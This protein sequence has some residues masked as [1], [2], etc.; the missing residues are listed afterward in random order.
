MAMGIW[1]PGGGGADL[2]VVTA[3]A[4]DVLAGKVIV[5]RMGNRSPE[6]WHY[7]AML[8]TDRY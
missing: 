7:P 3:D 8:L 1:L 5:A 6:P 2:D 4:G